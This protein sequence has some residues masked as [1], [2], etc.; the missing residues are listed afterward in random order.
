MRFTI[1]LFLGLVLMMMNISGRPKIYMTEDDLGATADDLGAAADDLG[2]TV[3]IVLFHPHPHRHVDDPLEVGPFHI[4]YISYFKKT[5]I[6]SI[7]SP[8]KKRYKINT[9]TNDLIFNMYLFF[10]TLILFSI[11]PLTINCYTVHDNT[12]LL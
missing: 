4:L 8:H 5:Q 6:E 7:L 1:V 3:H 11:I 12:F 10:A 9:T 2:A